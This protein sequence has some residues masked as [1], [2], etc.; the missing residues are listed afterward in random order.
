MHV[1]WVFWT[2]D[3]THSLFYLY[4]VFKTHAKYDCTQDLT[5]Y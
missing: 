4:T 3:Q 1:T 5:K 2:M